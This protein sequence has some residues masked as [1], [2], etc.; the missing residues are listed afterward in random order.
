MTRFK[1]VPSAQAVGLLQTTPEHGTLADQNVGLFTTSRN[2]KKLLH[3]KRNGHGKPCTAFAS[4][5]LASTTTVEVTS[6]RHDGKSGDGATKS[7]TSSNDAQQNNHEHFEYLP[8]GISRGMLCLS[9]WSSRSFECR[10]TYEVAQRS[11]IHGDAC[12]TF[13]LTVPGAWHSN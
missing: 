3:T 12:N 6:R 2:A 5:T 11:C 9:R 10:S 13:T 7:R 1:C 4:L 8:I